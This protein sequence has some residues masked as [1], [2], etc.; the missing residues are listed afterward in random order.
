VAIESS[1]GAASF[2]FSSIHRTEQLLL[3]FKTLS[4]EMVANEPYDQRRFLVPLRPTVRL[5]PFRIGRGDQN[6][7]TGRMSHSGV[8][9]KTIDSTTES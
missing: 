2:L 3:R 4:V 6:V 5:K 1:W 7:N 9:V 8:G